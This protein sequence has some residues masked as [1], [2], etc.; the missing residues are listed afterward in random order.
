VLNRAAVISALIGLFAVVQ[1][2]AAQVKLES[3]KALS[4]KYASQIDTARIRANIEILSSSELMGR[5]TAETGQKLAAAFLRKNMIDI[6]LS[7]AIGDTGYIQPY[8]LYKTEFQEGHIAVGS[9]TL[10]MLEHFYSFSSIIDSTIR[11]HNLLFLG[12]GISDDGYDNYGDRDVRGMA[13]IIFGG[14]PMSGDVSRIS[15]TVIPTSW[16]DGYDAKLELARARGLSILFVVQESF[17]QNLPRVTYYLQRAKLSLEK[18]SNS[19]LPIVFISPEMVDIMLPDYGIS[20][21]KSALESADAEYNIER[22]CDISFTLQKSVTT[23]QGENVACMVKGKV[24]PDEFIVLSGHYDHLGMKDSLIYHGA[25]DNGSGTS[26]VLELMRIFAQ[27][28]KDGNGP[29]RSVLFLFF[30]GE[31]KGLL[32]SSYFT[33]FPTIPLKSA[34]ANINVDMIGRTDTQK[35]LN[36][37]Y[38]YLIGSDKLSI[39]LHDLSEQVNKRCCDMTLDYK[40]NDPN[41]PQ[42]L[43]YRSDHYNFAKHGI[44]VI[45]YF[46]GLHEDYHKT[47]DTVDKIEF[48]TIEKVSKL[49]FYTVWELANRKERIKVDEALD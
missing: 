28:D 42:R 46:R 15:K 26:T 24:K 31:E 44:P 34:V 33:D 35:D 47:T 36:D 41:D 8:P 12:Y 13:G 37:D 3:D 14:E 38:I 27:A 18:P 11:A 45:F 16:S 39:E 5:E 17:N 4:R 23:V 43:Y 30:S 7:P 10:V 20:G 2:L 19:A 1:P 25:D 48:D 49:I 6:G 22:R 32:G 21:V 9:D 40:F 29:S